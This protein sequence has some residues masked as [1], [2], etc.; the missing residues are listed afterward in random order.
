MYVAMLTSARMLKTMSM[1][2]SESM[3]V[4][5]CIKMCGAT[6]VCNDVMNMA[7]EPSTYDIVVMA[8]APALIVGMLRVRIWSEVSVT[9]SV[10]A[11][12]SASISLHVVDIATLKP[13]VEASGSEF[14]TGS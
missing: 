12:K 2:W 6:M 9:V 14:G 7:T 11:Q 3:L 1:P 5:N 10:A 8:S 13:T 4:A